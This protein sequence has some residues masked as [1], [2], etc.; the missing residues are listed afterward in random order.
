M[1]NDINAILYKINHNFF[2]FWLC[3]VLVAEHGVFNWGMRT[4]SCGMRDQVPWPGIHPGPCTGLWEWS[5]SHWIT[6]KV[7]IISDS[8]IKCCHFLFHKVPLLALVENSSWPVKP[9]LT[10]TKQTDLC[11]LFLQSTEV[12]NT[13][14]FQNQNV[15]FPVTIKAQSLK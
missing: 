2:C 7:P 8:I 13:V 14:S 3:W 9:L 4:L 6:R 1:I 15:L 5:L 10:L 12:A 11:L